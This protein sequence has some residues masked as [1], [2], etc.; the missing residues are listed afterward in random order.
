[1]KYIRL[2]KIE[3]QVGLS[4]ATLH[5]QVPVFYFNLTGL[6]S[7]SI[8][9]NFVKILGSKKIFAPMK[10]PLKKVLWPKRFE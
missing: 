2:D 8:Q 9:F 6:P 1:M 3:K 10:L 4:R 5:P 7:K